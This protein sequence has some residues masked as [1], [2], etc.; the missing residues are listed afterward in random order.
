LVGSDHA[1]HTAAEKQLDFAQAPAGF[2]GVQTLFPILLDLALRDQ[3]PV[4]L[5]PTILTENPARRYG[6][7]STKGPVQF[8][9]DADF[10]LV[11]PKS[12]TCLTR[13]DLYSLNP[14]NPWMGRNLR[15]T[16]QATYLRGQLIA[17]HGRVVDTMIGQF[18][19][20]GTHS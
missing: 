16:L 11:D 6:L 5:L 1:P 7:I 17:E 2:A 10:V 12:T 20:P 18:I 13:E 14:E 8:G 15:G 4:T 3:L 9:L 19:T